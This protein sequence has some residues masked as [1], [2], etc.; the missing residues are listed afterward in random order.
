MFYPFLRMEQAKKVKK[1]KK[2]SPPSGKKRKAEVDS[3]DE[4]PVVKTF[5]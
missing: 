2:D 5:F 4:K 1:E 3:E